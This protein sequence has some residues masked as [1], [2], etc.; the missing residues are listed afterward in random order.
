MLGL[1][2]VGANTAKCELVKR[3]QQVVFKAMQMARSFPTRF[4]VAAAIE[5]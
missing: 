2:M 1:S 3:R 5:L 4:F